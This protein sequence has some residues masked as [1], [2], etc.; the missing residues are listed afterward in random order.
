[1]DS[2]SACVLIDYQNAHLTGR[3]LHR[4]WGEPAHLSL[5][6]PMLLAERLVEK[7]SVKRAT[8]LEA[9]RVFRGRPS[10]ERQPELTGYND[11]QTANWERD[12]RLKV[13]RRE[14][15]YRG[16]PEHPPRE[17]GVDVS[18]AIELIRSTLAEE[19]DA[20]IVFT[21]DTDLIPALELAFYQT[22]PSLELGTW[23]GKR[24]L[25]FA[26]ELRQRRNLPYCHFL[27]QQDFED[28]QDK[29][30]YS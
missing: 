4:G 8:T 22:K 2:E 25:W 27:S 15:N 28:C 1:M 26:G 11:A 18:L 23:T 14:L 17:K 12:E 9:V 3:E 29:T 30:Q 5:V 21:A 20:Y 7:R 19:Y 6:H 13:I 10:P 16:W 24:P